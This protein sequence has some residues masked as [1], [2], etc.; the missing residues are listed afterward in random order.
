MAPRLFSFLAILTSLTSGA[1]AGPASANGIFYRAEPAAQPGAER[2]VVR[3]LVWKCGAGACVSG[4][5]NSRAPVDCA[6][7]V[8]QVGA[9]KSFVVEGQALPPSDLEKCNARAR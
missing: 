4:R 3:D 9:L 6:A 2:I 5:S 1:V 8:R 7:L